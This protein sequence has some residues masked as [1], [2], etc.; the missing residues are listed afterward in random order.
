MFGALEEDIDEYKKYKE[1]LYVKR[2]TTFAT[3]TGGKFVS[4]QLLRKELFNPTDDDNIATTEW[5]PALGEITANCMIEE[6]E[7]DQKVTHWHLS[8]L[9]GRLSFKECPDVE[10]AALVRKRATNNSAESAFSS[11]THQLVTY[12]TIDLHTAAGTAEMNRN[13]YY[14]QP[15]TKKHIKEK[16]DHRMMFGINFN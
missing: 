1:Y 8:K 2:K 4:F 9:K 14:F 7:N 10:K 16:V 5:M 13:D 12:N 3:R 15:T 6:L 11:F